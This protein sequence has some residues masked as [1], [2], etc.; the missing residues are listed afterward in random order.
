MI[1]HD[2]IAEI[3]RSTTQ[4][5]SPNFSLIENVERSIVAVMVPADDGEQL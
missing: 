4:F 5:C 1:R 3:T 2:R